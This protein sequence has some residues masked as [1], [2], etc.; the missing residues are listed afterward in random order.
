MGFFNKLKLG[1]GSS[2]ILQ[3]SK[4]NQKEEAKKIE[5]SSKGHRNKNEIKLLNQKNINLPESIMSTG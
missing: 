3:E 2:Q 5:K 1:N 4:S